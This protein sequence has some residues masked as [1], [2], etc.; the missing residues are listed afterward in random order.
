MG[1][2]LKNNSYVKIGRNR[3]KT[4]DYPEVHTWIRTGTKA[5]LDKAKDPPVYFTCGHGD[6]KSDEHNQD[7]K[8]EIRVKARHDGRLHLLGQGIR[9]LPP[10]RRPTSPFAVFF[11][12]ITCNR[13]ED[14]RRA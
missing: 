9:Q 13:V 12:G 8:D 1:R 10:I 2:P 11:T 14:Q 5:N 7:A 3:L 6:S 4:A